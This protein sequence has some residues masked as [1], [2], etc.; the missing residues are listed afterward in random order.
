MKNTLLVLAAILII[1]WFVI[2]PAIASADDSDR[3]TATAGDET[4]FDAALKKAATEHKRVL[5]GFSGSDW[6]HWCQ[7]M[8]REVLSTADFK[9]YADQHLVVLIADFPARRQLP[10]DVAAQNNFLKNRYRVDGYP[11]F[12]V[13][14]P[15]GAEIDRVSGYVRGGPQAFI[16]ILKRTESA[17]NASA[18]K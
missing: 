11:T 14:S 16:S 10:D 1:G 13:L 18:Q 12:V 15:Q 3:P 9:A 4:S 2:R 6:C 5:L 8:D 7:V 17:E